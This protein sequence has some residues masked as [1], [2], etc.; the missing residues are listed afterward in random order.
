MEKFLI[1]GRT[2]LSGKLPVNGAK[3]HALKLIPA[4]FLF[5]GEVTLSNVPEIEDIKRL[6][7]IV[8]NIGGSVKHEGGSISIVAPE[9]FDGELPAD[10]VPQLRASIVLVGPLLARY[11]SV[12]LPLP[13]GDNI[14]QRPIDFFVEGCKAMGANVKIKDDTY[15]FKAKHGLQGAEFLFP[16]VSVTGTETLLLA[17]TQASGTTVLKNAAC[18]PEIVALAEFLNAHG[19]KITGAGTHTITIEGTGLFAGGQAETIPDR[20]EAGSFVILAAATQSNLTI[21]KCN[22]AH[23]EIPLYILQEMGVETQV[24]ADSIEVIPPKGKLKPINLVTHEYPGFPT[25]LQAPMTVLLTQ[26]EGQSHV[27]ET[28]YESRLVYT[29]L[30]NSMG[31]DISL[32]DPFRASIT[33]PTELQGKTV[34]SPDI[35]AGIAMIIAGLIAEGTTTI[36]NI[37]QIDRGY[38]RI[39]ERLQAVGAQIRR[40]SE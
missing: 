7:E 40:V 31:A 3:N 22:P 27:R 10:L 35:R 6:V 32:L 24:G 19:A 16:L 23:L 5:T 36:Q 14:G 20:I 15:I 17:A 30:L 37:Y 9:A 8:D 34:A 1:E 2:E 26:A 13:G 4:A 25:D 12:S 28:I 39:E 11:G 33:G 29:D 18:E 21:T 38:E